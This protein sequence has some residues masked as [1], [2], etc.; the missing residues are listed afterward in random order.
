[1]LATGSGGLAA[2]GVTTF[3]VASIKPSPPNQPFSCA[4][5]PGGVF[6]CHHVRAEW[7]LRLAFGLN[8]T[9]PIK[10]VP[11]WRDDLYDIDAKAEGAGEMTLAELAAPML[12]LF[13]DRFG[14]VTHEEPAKQTVYILEQLKSGARL[15]PSPPGTEYSM[16]QSDEGVLFKAETMGDL[17]ANLGPK[18]DL[19]TT[20]IDN[21]GLAGKFDFTLPYINFGRTLP[22]DASPELTRKW[23]ASVPSTFDAVDSIGLRLRPEKRDGTVLVIDQIHK[24][25]PN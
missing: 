24:P 4:T 14:L 22:A 10:G 5:L 20:V 9:A 2:Q 12:A 15:E 1:M 6:T 19:N 18:P 16:K 13:R 3:D 17:A 7:F 11:S 8:A 25:T 23:A 21:T